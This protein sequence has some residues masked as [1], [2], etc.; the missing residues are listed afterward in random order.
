MLLEELLAFLLGEGAIRTAGG[1]H[2]THLVRIGRVGSQDC[3]AIPLVSAVQG[4][5]L[6]V[7]AQAGHRSQ[8][9]VEPTDFSI[10][11]CSL[12]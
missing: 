12:L 8:V 5:A 7:Q 6:G 9:L 11:F 2:R 3:Y 1:E 4:T 10:H